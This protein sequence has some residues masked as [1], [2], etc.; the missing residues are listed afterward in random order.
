MP[1]DGW[2]GLIADVG[3]VFGLVLGVTGACAAMLFVS[4]LSFVKAV[5]P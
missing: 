4:I 2:Q 5:A 3:T 1:G